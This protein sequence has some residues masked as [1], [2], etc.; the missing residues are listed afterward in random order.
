MEFLETSVFTKQITSILLDYEYADLQ[1]YLTRHPDVGSL[2]PC[3]AGLRKVRWKARGKGKRSG[4]RI[5][6]YWYFSKSQIFMLLAY[7]KSESTDLSK[8]HLKQLAKFVKEGI[9]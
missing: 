7:K 9:L 8:R 1:I 6:Y 5:I 2:I 3:G 4:V